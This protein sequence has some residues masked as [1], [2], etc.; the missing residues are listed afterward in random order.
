[1]GKSKLLSEVRTEIRKQNYSYHLEQ[2]YIGWMVRFVHFHDLEHPQNLREAEVVQ[3]LNHL[4]VNRDAAASIQDQ[5][6]SAISF[7]YKHVIKEPLNKLQGLIIPMDTHRR[8]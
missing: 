2:A 7:Y 6:R 4:S 5:A 1:M 3:Y 8:F